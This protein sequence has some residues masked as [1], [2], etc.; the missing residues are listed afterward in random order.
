MGEVE[1]EVARSIPL[2]NP[3]PTSR[4]REVQ[5]GKDLKGVDCDFRHL[6]VQHLGGN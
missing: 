5:R 4:G 1:A 3:Y 6:W 2:A